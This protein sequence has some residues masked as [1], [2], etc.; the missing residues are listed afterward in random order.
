[1]TAP[2]WRLI[3]RLIRNSPVRYVTSLIGWIAIWSMPLV[4]G[5]IAAGFFDSLAGQPTGWDLTT[6][7]AAVWGFSLGRVAVLLVAM[8]LHSSLLFRTSSAM[9]RAMMGWI[10]KLPA[11]QPV[12]ESPGEVVSRFRDDVNHTTEAFDFTVD[13]ISAIISAAVAVVVLANID[14]FITAVVFAPIIAVVFIVSRVGQMIRRFRTEARDKTEAI[15]GFLGE[16]LG[17][18]QSVKVADAEAPML[19][20][21]EAL[22]DDRRVAMVKDRTFT[23]GIEAVF[24]NTVSVGTGLILI[25]VA[26]SLSID[27]SAGMTIGQFALFVS[28]LSMVTDSAWFIGVFLARLRQAEVSVERNIDLMRGA[29]WPDLAAE[30]EMKEKLVVPEVEEPTPVPGAPFGDRLRSQFH[31]R[32]VTGRDL[33]C[34]PGD[35]CRIF[36]GGDRQDRGRQNHSAP[37][38]SRSAAGSVGHDCLEGSACGFARCVHGSTPCRLHLTG[39]PALLDVTPRQSVVGP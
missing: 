18:V 15:T 24:H 5:L 23:A 22:N 28:Y 12:E 1:M 16:M 38:D 8:R 2:I 17:S 10:Y 27:G 19:H 3:W 26:G 34:G 39:P 37:H 32:V 25:L 33:R 31:L 29:E 13:L 35:S 20:H 36:C 6:V 30:I 14:P 21:F 11:A 9:R 4:I 7:I